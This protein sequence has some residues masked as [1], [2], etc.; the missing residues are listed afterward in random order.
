MS[1]GTGSRSYVRA[2]FFLAPDGV[3]VCVGFSVRGD[4]DKG[5]GDSEA[6]EVSRFLAAFFIQ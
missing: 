2:L 3:D 4:D 1:S 6:N 5:S